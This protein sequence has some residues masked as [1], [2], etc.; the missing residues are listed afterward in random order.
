MTDD[1]DELLSDAALD[2][3]HVRAFLPMLYVAWADG[4]LTDDEIR[5]IRQQLDEMPWV[6]AG[7]RKTL[8]RLLDPEEPPSAATLQRILE[9]VREAA[10]N[11]DDDRRLHLARLGAALSSDDPNVEEAVETLL[12]A[13]DIDGAEAGRA[14]LGGMPA[15]DMVDETQRSFDPEALRAVLE[16]R[17]RAIRAKARAFLDDP[18]VR[19]DRDQTK[20]DAREAVLKVVARLAEEGFGA[21]AYPG[22][23]GEGETLEDFMTAFETLGYGDLSVLVKFGVQFGLFG[24]S[25]YFLG[26]EEQRE[27]WLPETAK[28]QL[29]G[30]FAMTEL[31]HG[32]NVMGLETTATYDPESDSI[33]VHTPSESARKEWIGNAAAHARMATVFAQLRVGDQDHGVHAVL[34]RIR[35]AEGEPMPGVRLGDCGHK[36]GLN[37][38]DNGRIWFDQVKVPRDHL[39]GRFAKITEDGVYESPIASPNKRFFTMLGTLVAGRV[40]VGSGAV[41][42]SKVGLAIATR[43]AFHRR[44]F[45]APGVPENR[46]ID[47]PIHRRRL[48]PPLAQTYAASFAIEHARRAYVEADGEEERRAVEALAA[49]IKAF[50]TDHATFALQRCRE[51]CGG[52]GYLSANRIGPLKSDTDVFTTFEGDNTVLLQLVAK[53]VLTDFRK[54]LTDDR[55]FGLIRYV[56]KK[57][58]RVAKEANP[59]TSRLSSADHLR[60]R[61]TLH[62]L[63]TF[64]E[65]HL[66]EAAARRVQRRIGDGMKPHEA[67]TDIQDHLV[68][69]AEAHVE[70]IVFDAFAAAVEGADEVAKKPLDRLLDLWSL[71]RIEQDLGWFME[72]GVAEPSRASGVRDQV[73]KLCDEVAEDAL[74]YVE[75][76]GIPETSLAA[77]IAFGSDAGV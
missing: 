18:S 40:S 38:V 13:L 52:Q 24:G 16:P 46:L 58:A 69:M 57:I 54:E 66:V 3:P 7:A 71:W 1:S 42:A 37:G 45:G 28:A 34:V 76:F 74:A 41:S 27:R 68:A 20:G 64:R 30:C 59:I 25:I 29:L 56:G 11:L 77:P 6:H 15:A 60:D 10:G 72:N 67:F 31:G 53:A 43:Y 14:L 32:S 75:A 36:L 73:Q 19:I 39:L 48:M 17:G 5:T 9:T 8:D 35:N 47:Y 33:V 23:I 62:G 26:N 21:L 49:G 22:V 2:A 50:A 12:A 63:F 44:Q 70:R 61:D 55:V 65:S 51:C 4:E